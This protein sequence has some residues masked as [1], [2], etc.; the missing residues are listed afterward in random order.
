MENAFQK[1]K[2]NVEA[3]IHVEALHTLEHSKMEVDFSQMLMSK[4]HRRQLQRIYDDGFWCRLRTSASQ[5]QVHLR[6]DKVQIDNPN[7]LS[8]YPTIF[9]PVPLPESVGHKPL[10]EVLLID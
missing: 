7:P 9:V 1:Y 5:Y 3:D 2:E 10:I 6:M 4:P 8:Q